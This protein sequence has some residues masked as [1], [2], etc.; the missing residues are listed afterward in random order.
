MAKAISIKLDKERHLR[1][2][3]G[4]IVE[5]EKLAGVKMTNLPPDIGLDMLLL[6]VYCGLKHE[7]KT[8]TVEKVGDMIDITMIPSINKAI[9]KC[10][11]G[12]K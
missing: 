3:L 8:L 11:K 2:T 1:F 7:D 10:F 12:L 5:F 9:T 4:A 6:L